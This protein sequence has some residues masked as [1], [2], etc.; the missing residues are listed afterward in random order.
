MRFAGSALL[1]VTLAAGLISCGDSGP[2]AVTPV[3]AAEEPSVSASA[4]AASARPRSTSFVA[5]GPLIVED[6]VD[7]AAQRSGVVAKIL[8][9]VGQPVR[10]GQL[11]ALLDD[12][13]LTA[14]RDADQAQLL[15][16]K[17]NLKD[18][19]AETK[20]AEADFRRADGMY[21]AQLNTREELDHARYKWEGSRFEIEKANQQLLRSQATLQAAN[22]ELE[23]TRIRAP[24]AGVVARRYISLGQQVGAGDRIFWVTAVSPLRVKFTLP[25]SFIGHIKRGQLLNVSCLD[26]PGIKHAARVI[27]VSPVVDPSSGTFE[28]LAQLLHPGRNLRPGMTASI[29]LENRQ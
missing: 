24:F 2:Q 12:R 4:S 10:K 25:Q 6:Q 22:L 17:A 15:A 28:V 5:S 7:V 20:M 3:L 26:A 14:Q 1:I 27:Q 8:A 9:D 11:L 16:A 19:E 21:K 13:Q 18:W 23:K 29:Q